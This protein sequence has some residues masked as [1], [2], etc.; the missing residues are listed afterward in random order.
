MATTKN[1]LIFILGISRIFATLMQPLPFVIEYIINKK[2]WVISKFE[3]WWIL[4]KLLL[5]VHPCS[6]LAQL[7]LITFFFCLCK[8]ITFWIFMCELI[9]A[10]SWNSWSHFFI[11][12]KGMHLGFP[13][14]YK[15]GN[16]HFFCPRYHLTN[17]KVYKLGLNICLF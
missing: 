14:H 12:S 15:L 5:V 4:W 16:W 2:W 13:F 6:I 7:A 8:F 10:P 9:L 1:L 3:T 17:L 11:G